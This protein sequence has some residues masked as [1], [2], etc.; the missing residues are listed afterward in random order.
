MDLTAPAG[1]E[2]PSM[3]PLDEP[4]ALDDLPSPPPLELPSGEAEEAAGQVD[5]AGG[6]EEQP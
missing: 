4:A 6:G 3:L 1:Q 2:A 5:D